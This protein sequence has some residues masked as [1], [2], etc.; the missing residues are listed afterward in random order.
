MSP[1]R[2]QKN[3]PRGLAG[4]HFFMY[5]CTTALASHIAAQGEKER[6]ERQIAG[7]SLMPTQD[8]AEEESP[9]NAGLVRFLTGSDP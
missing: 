3:R 4:C 5:L 9:G 7:L 2:S 1:C 6:L 8:E